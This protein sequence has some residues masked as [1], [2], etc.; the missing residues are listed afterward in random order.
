MSFTINK[1]ASVTNLSKRLKEAPHL[2]TQQVQ[3]IINESVITIENNARARAPLGQVNGGKLKASIYSTPYTMNAGAR[4]GSRGY[5][6]RRSNYSPFVEF[7]TGNEFQIP[8]Y[9][10]LSMNKLEAYALS[11]KRSNG[12]LVNLPHRPFLFLSASEELYK[13]VNKIK[14][15]KI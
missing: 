4:V 12:N 7:G 15:I 3:K 6:G 11:F 2:I 9:R 5:M 1:T 14:K 13:M 10:N 8:V